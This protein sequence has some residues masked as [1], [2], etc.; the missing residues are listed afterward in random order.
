[1][2]DRIICDTSIYMGG[3]FEF[4]RKHKV[5]GTAFNA[6]ELIN[7]SC[8][9]QDKFEILQRAVIKFLDRTEDIIIESTQ[10][11][12][13]GTHL[14]N[15]LRPKSK[16]FYKAL[17]GSLNEIKK[18]KDFNE[19][20]MKGLFISGREKD[21]LGR[22]AMDSWLNDLV[23]KVKEYSGSEFNEELAYL[24]LETNLRE[25]FVS[26]LQRHYQ[27]TPIRSKFNL[28][29]KTPYIQICLSYIARNIYALNQEVKRNTFNDLEHLIYLNGNDYMFCTNEVDWNDLMS[30]NNITKGRLLKYG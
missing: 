5:I 28:D 18:A 3:S 11:H 16:Y 12:L 22:I 4:F 27:V 2:S 29:I 17:E 23:A 25:H 1:M 8:Y 24:I 26:F 14:N 19:C 7:S 30:Y 21:N 10:V 13:L 9:N 6:W 15:R 20:K